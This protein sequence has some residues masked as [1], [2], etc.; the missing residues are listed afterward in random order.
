MWLV[1]VIVNPLFGI[2]AI[3]NSTSK[4]ILPARWLSQLSLFNKTVGAKL[5]L[6]MTGIQL[7]SILSQSSSSE[8]LMLLVILFLL[9]IVK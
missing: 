1:K 7:I 4:L 3:V 5:V 9:S 2:D 6:C 8:T